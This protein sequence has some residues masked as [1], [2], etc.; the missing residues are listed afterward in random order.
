M[1]P[2]LCALFLSAGCA[3]SK[4]AVEPTPASETKLEV[5]GPGAEA[6]PPPV[7]DPYLWLEEV[8]GKKPLAWAEAQNKKALAELDS[9]AREALRKQLLAIFDSKEKIPYVDAKGKWLFNFWRDEQHERG[10]WRRVSVDGYKQKAPA[11]ETVLDLDALAAAEK[12][13]WVYKGADCLKPKE[14][15]CLL[16]LSRGGGDAT[17]T[18]EF[19]TVKKQF[20]TDGFVLPEAK[21]SITWKDE[22]TVFVGTDFG[23]GTLTTSGYPRLVKEWKRGTPLEKATLIAEAKEADVD[24]YAYRDQ[25]QNRTLDLVMRSPTFFSS[26]EFI[27][28]NGKLEKLDKPDDAKTGFFGEFLLLELRSDWKLGEKTFPA[29]ALLATKLKDFRAGKRDFE[30]LF[31]PAKNK[32]LLAWTRTKS[33]FVLNELEDV[34]NKLWVL[35]PE[36]GKWKRAALPL[37]GIGSY[38]VDAFDSSTSD[39]YWLH[40]SDF[41]QPPSLELGDLKTN[42]RELLKSM[43]AFFDASGL[44]TKQSF[45]TS[46]DGTKVPYFVVARKDLKL[47]GNTPVLMTAYGGFE[48]SMTPSYSGAN[49]AAWLDKGAFVL[50]NIRGGGEYGPQWHE[51]AI[52][53]NRQRAYDDFIAVAEDLIARKITSSKR[54]G[55]Q[56]ASNGGLLMGVML[57]QRPELFGAIVCSVPLLDMKRYHTLLAGASW[58]GEYGDPGVPDEWAALA[59]FSPY[60]NVKKGTKYPRILFTTSTLDDRVH[61]G[62][63][64]KMVARMLEQGHDVQYFENTEGGHGGAANNAQKANL[65]S[66]EYAFLVN[67]LTR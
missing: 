51:S 63:A 33:H 50:A 28:E 62:H 44:E 14:E 5:T 27:L 49:G 43:P 60:Q 34:R 1:R 65:Y 36:K 46:K 30:V 21:P 20:V 2:L 17:V 32:S 56:G 11:W 67:Q 24:I 12:E 66:L 22:N 8:S 31:E 9:P 54:L 6:Q 57:T 59:K 13:N 35:T 45:A 25:H 47:D 61:P 41:T 10:L 55:I 39:Q 29:G 3:S 4:P 37:P 64:R 18:R 52:K 7:E 42:K 26:E 38:E 58:M 16:S 48:V 23:P 15:R 19:D 40:V 53:Q